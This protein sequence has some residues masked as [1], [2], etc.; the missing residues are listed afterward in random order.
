MLYCSSCLPKAASPARLLSSTPPT[1]ATVL[2]HPSLFFFNDPAPPEIYTLSLHD[3]LPI[4][5]IDMV[6]RKPVLHVSMMYPAS[7]GCLALTMPLC[8]HPTNSNGIIVYDLRE[9]PKGWTGLSVD[10]IK[11]R[12]FTARD[13]LGEGVERIGLK[14]I[15]I[16]KCPVVASPAVLSR[17][18]AE[19]FGLDLDEC[20]QHWSSLQGDKD[21]LDKI[22]EVFSEEPGQREVDPD[23]MIYSGGFFSDADKSLMAMIRSA[24]ATDLARLDLP[25]RD[26]RLSTMLQRYRARNYRETLSSQELA[27]WNEFRRGRL[28][29]DEALAAY[30]QGYAEAKERAGDGRQ[31]LFKNLDDY[32]AAITAFE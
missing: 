23:F 25:F 24:S 22:A 31:D 17:E 29:S 30:E 3:A 8:P 19:L 20:R 4:S 11:K 18:R 1:L 2:T 7:Q 5:E 12:V 16:N 27:D 9:D 26:P 10:E 32:V 28:V 13:E 6:T 14:T 21:I 15:H